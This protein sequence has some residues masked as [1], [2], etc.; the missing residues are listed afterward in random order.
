[1]GLYS[2]QEL[3]AQ[4]ADVASRHPELQKEIEKRQKWWEKN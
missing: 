1:M 3:Q 4:I 2:D